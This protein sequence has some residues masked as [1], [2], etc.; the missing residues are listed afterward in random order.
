MEKQLQFCGSL[1]SLI[2]IPL[3]ITDGT[4]TKT[5][6]SLSGQFLREGMLELVLND[7]RV[8]KRDTLHP[9]ISYVDPGFFIGVAELLPD[10]YAVVGPVS[11][12]QHTRQEIL[13][14][15][16]YALMPESLQT[17]VD[18]LQSQ[19]LISLL[20]L[21]DCLCL[22]IKL[23]QNTEIPPDNILLNDFSFQVPVSTGSLDQGL[24]DMREEIQSHVP[25]DYEAAI[26]DAIEAGNVRLLERST[27][28]AP[29][30]GRVGRMSSSVLQQHRYELV[31]LATLISR[32]AI[33]GGLSAETAFNLSDIYCQRVDVLSEAESIQ[34][35]T[36]QMMLDFCRKVEELHQNPSVS[37]LIQKCTEYIS[38]HLHEQITLDDLSDHCALCGRSLSIR[39]RKE[40]GMGINEYIHREKIKEARYLL[41]HSDYTLSQ[42]S[43]FLNY[44][45]QSYFTQIFRRYMGQTPL[46]YRESTQE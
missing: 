5:W 37:P 32:A 14:F 42:I 33:R 21:K 30:S 13:T 15:C 10:I 44:P 4:E 2:R 22:L 24:F 11:P 25:I 8:Q 1:Y 43:L 45:S 41:R 46:Q 35:L 19:P 38:V 27:A 26:C 12:F 39:F 34:R 9:L 3:V 17:Y 29:S 31:S 18:T 16:S 28:S 20:Q 23:S 6:P 36:Y 40:T 7:F